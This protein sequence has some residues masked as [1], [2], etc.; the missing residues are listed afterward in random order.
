MTLRASRKDDPHIWYDF[1]ISTIARAK[2]VTVFID[3]NIDWSLPS[4]NH[5]EVYDGNY[6]RGNNDIYPDAARLEVRVFYPIRKVY[7][8][9]VRQ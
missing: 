7:M 3:A 6:G 9:M 2:D 1:A 4:T 8:P 5:P